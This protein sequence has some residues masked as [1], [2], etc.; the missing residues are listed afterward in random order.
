MTKLFVYSSA[1]P[2]AVWERCRQYKIE[3]SYGHGTETWFL[4]GRRLKESNYRC[5]EEVAVYSHATIPD[6]EPTSS[7]DKQ[8]D[9]IDGL[10]DT[11]GGSCTYRLAVT[12]GGLRTYRSV[13]LVNLPP[14]P[15]IRLPAGLPVTKDHL[16]KLT[17]YIGRYLFADNLP[18]G[19]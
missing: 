7:L 15:T 16:S 9:Q 6:N 12:P 8:I 10:A 18:S 13:G 14:R 5:G 19:I 2:E 17:A 1:T 11:R 3:R 4:Q